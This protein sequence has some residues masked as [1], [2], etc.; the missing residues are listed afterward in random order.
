M[1][2]PIQIPKL[3]SGGAINQSESLAMIGDKQDYKPHLKY[4]R[5]KKHMCRLLK[6]A[7][8]KADIHHAV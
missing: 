6:K 4:R 3:S 1:N 5:Y 2:E 8:K 7:L